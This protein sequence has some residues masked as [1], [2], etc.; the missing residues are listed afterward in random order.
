MTSVGDRIGTAITRFVVSHSDWRSGFIVALNRSFVHGRRVSCT[1]AVCMSADIVDKQERL[2]CTEN[3]LT[4]E[5]YLHVL[6]KI[7]LN[8]SFLQAFRHD[9]RGAFPRF[10]LLGCAVVT[11]Q[12]HKT[13]LRTARRRAAHVGRFGGSGRPIRT[14]WASTAHWLSR[15]SGPG[16]RRRILHSTLGSDLPPPVKFK[17]SQNNN[18]IKF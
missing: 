7:V 13:V 11:S 8:S 1:V 15:S 16:Y 10:V 4:R 12:K 3:Y 17:S 14:L 2:A 5:A 9:R 18:V 6:V